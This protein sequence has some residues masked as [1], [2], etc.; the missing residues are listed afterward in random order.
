MTSPILV[1]LRCVRR[2]PRTALALSLAVLG[3]ADSSRAELPTYSLELLVRANAPGNPVG[4]FRIPLGWSISSETPKVNDVGQLALRVPATTNGTQALWFGDRLGGDIVFETVSFDAFLSS[5]F[6]I[7]THGDVVFS[8]VDTPGS[9]NGLYL[10]RSSTGAPPSFFSNKPEGTSLWGSPTFDDSGRVAVRAKFPSYQAHAVINAAG[11]DA[12]IYVREK[13]GD[14]AS[15]FEFL[16][17]PSMNEVGQI[18]SVASPTIS[19]LVFEIRRWNPDGSSVRIAADEVVTPGSPYDRFDSTST[20]INNAGRVSFVA[21]LVGGGRGVFVSDG[22]TTTTIAV[23][24]QNGVGSIESFPT[25]LNDSGLVAFRAFDS[26]GLRAVWV[27][28]GVSLATVAR[29]NDIVPTDVGPGRIA[30]HDTSPVFGGAPVINQRGDVSFNAGLTPPEDNQI[31]WGSGVFV[32]FA[33]GGAGAGGAG[34]A[35]G[36]AGTSGAGGAGGA[37]G[38]AGTGGVG[39]AGGEAGTGGSAGEAGS[40]GSAGEAG[41]SGSAGEAGSGGAS[42]EAGSGGSA[43][44]ASG[45]AGSSGGAGAGGEGGGLAGSGTGGSSGNPGDAGTGGQGG[46]AAGSGQ[47]GSGVAGSSTGPGTFGSSG[48]PL[49]GT[50]GTSNENGGTTYEIEGGCSVGPGPAGA[51][52][53]FFA[54]LLPWSV[55]AL[56]RRLRREKRPAKR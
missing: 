29:Q 25:S 50:G 6:A 10:F 9:P 23:Q 11:T 3:L 16:Y 21:N 1:P 49:A 24:G 47:A 51:S 40:S 22:V 26:A 7:N 39:G 42:G 8:L 13:G 41:T 46:G 44:G 48:A 4:S 37:G 34:G 33:Q 38:E 19:P 2:A 5:D 53:R 43:G 14:P 45:E 30:Q 20:S 36:E 17:A 27:G 56:G 15:P 35:G 52:G 31:E 28:D 54:A 32:A 55:L 12:T 18:A